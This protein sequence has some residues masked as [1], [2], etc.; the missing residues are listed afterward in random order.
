MFPLILLFLTYTAVVVVT[1]FIAIPLINKV[2]SSPYLLGF[3]PLP[4][5][6]AGPVTEATVEWL[7]ET[8]VCLRRAWHMALM[9]WRGETPTPPIII[10][11]TRIHINS[12]S[13]QLCFYLS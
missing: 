5:L 3:E 7:A 6:D 12:E 4:T 10:S 9:G 8:S 11:L 2:L 13:G 1:P